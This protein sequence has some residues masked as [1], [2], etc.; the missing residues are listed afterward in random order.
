[1][2][3]AL[4]TLLDPNFRRS[5]VLL[6]DHGPDGSL[7]VVINKPLSVE[8]GDLLED[9]PVLTQSGNVFDG[10]PVGKNSMLILCRGQNGPEG[11]SIFNDL[12][13]ANDLDRFKSDPPGGEAHDQIRC[14]LGYAGWAPD[15][16]QNELNAGAWHVINGDSSLVFDAEPSVLWQ[17]LIRRIGGP[18]AMYG[19]MPADPSL[20]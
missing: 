17:E 10:G 13:L 14:F 4:P 8:T 18:W 20:N 7:G 15:Q 1:M 19:E 12:Y 9:Y 2:L 16:L 6:C 3:I 5:V 11:H